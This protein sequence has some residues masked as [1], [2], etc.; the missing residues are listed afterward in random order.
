MKRLR[1]IFLGLFCLSVAVT[2]AAHR[3]ASARD[4]ERIKREV[5]HEVLMLPYYDV[6]DAIGY[7]VDGNTVTLTGAVTRPTLKTDTENAVK[8]IEGVE[9]V[10][11]NIEVLPPSPNDDRL[12][13]QLYRAIYGYPALEKYAL[14]SIK[15]IRIIVKNGR[16]SLEGTVNS[17][18]DKTLAGM[19]ANSVPGIF[20]VQNNLAVAS[21]KQA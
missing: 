7:K 13:L 5:M 12:R 10:I 3:Q 9:K 4:V 11:N 15:P 14:L 6:F 20:A 19:Q 17:E 2:A 1:T 16:V 21:G 18:G 8:K